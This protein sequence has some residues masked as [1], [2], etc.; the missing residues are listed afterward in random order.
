[1]KIIKRT[2]NSVHL[3]KNIYYVILE[4]KKNLVLYYL[5]QIYFSKQS[6]LQ[7]SYQNPIFK[8]FILSD[9]NFPPTIV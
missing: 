5:H 2:E 1:L 7:F 4:L 3:D 6:N 9:S 8:E